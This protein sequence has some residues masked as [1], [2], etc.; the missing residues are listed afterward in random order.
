MSLAKACCIEVPDFD[1]VH[2]ENVEIAPSDWATAEEHAFSI[3]RFDR[4]DQGR[5]HMEDFCQAGNLPGVSAVEISE[6]GRVRDEGRVP[7]LRSAVA[8]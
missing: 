2:R 8:C 5:V 3:A 7:E 4:S 1:L 6:F